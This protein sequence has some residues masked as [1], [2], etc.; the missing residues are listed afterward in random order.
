[1][2]ALARLGFASR[3]ALLTLLVASVWIAL[4]FA[5]AKFGG[6]PNSALA[7][8]LAAAVCWFGSFTALAATSLGAQASSAPQL[9]LARMLLATFARLVPPMAA[10]TLAVA[11]DWPIVDGGFAAYLVVFYLLTLAF[12]TA[13]ALPS[14][15]AAGRSQVEA[16]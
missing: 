5:R 10:I 13:F 2:E 4:H 15:L 14:T 11:R 16:V 6:E 8:D 12:D 7:L 3:A 9:A 1:M